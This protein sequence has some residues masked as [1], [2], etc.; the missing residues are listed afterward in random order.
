MDVQTTHSKIRVGTSSATNA[1]N[2]SFMAIEC[3]VAHRMLRLSRTTANTTIRLAG[4]AYSSK[5]LNTT[6]YV[7]TSMCVCV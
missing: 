3:T 1:E 6:H 7:C 2:Q 4:E 5:I